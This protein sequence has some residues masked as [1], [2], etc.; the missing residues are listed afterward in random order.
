MAQEE[1]GGFLDFPETELR[2]LVNIL[3]IKQGHG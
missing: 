3:L 2:V 1:I